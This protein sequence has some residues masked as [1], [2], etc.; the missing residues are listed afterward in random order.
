MRAFLL[1]ILL[2]AGCDDSEWERRAHRADVNEKIRQDCVP[3]EG[4]TVVVGYYRGYLVCRHISP[5][6]RLGKKGPHV[7]VEATVVLHVDHLTE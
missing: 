5:T 7:K 2:L 1:L 6:E 3:Q 4:S